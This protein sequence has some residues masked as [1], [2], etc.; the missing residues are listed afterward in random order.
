METKIF[1]NGNNWTSISIHELTPESYLEFKTCKNTTG[2]IV[3][4]VSLFEEIQKGLFKQNYKFSK[5]LLTN[6]E[7]IANKGKIT[8]MHEFSISKLES[9]LKMYESEKVTNSDLI[10]E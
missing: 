2:Q 7:N 10:L 1:K 9:V 5:I 4:K 8:E 6:Y 3:S